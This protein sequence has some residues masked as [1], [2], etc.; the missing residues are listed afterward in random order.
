MKIPSS[1]EIAGR[2][3]KVVENS[4]LGHENEWLGAAVYREDKIELQPSTK[5]RPRTKDCLNQ[6]FCHELVHWVLYSMGK[7]ELNRDEEFVDLF[8]TFLHQALKTMK[9]S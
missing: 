9:Y 6:T 3:V 2:K 8:G 1:F 7:H 5:D 4:R